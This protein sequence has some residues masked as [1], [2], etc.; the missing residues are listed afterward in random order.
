VLAADTG[1]LPPEQEVIHQP[2][3][4]IGEHI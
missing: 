4:M 1:G 3:P 2:P